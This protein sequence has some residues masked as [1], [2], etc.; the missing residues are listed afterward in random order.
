MAV[1]Q[2]SNSPVLTGTVT[3]C[4]IAE[5]QRCNTEVPAASNG[6]TARRLSD[7]TGL[8]AK[9]LDNNTHTHTPVSYTHLTLPT[10]VNV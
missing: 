7:I 2:G 9:S 4:R 8:D 1:T 10:K 6:E 3:R 5:F